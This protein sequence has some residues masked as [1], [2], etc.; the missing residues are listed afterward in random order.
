MAFQEIAGAKAAILFNKAD[1]AC[2]GLTR[3]PGAKAVKV[4]PCI[5]KAMKRGK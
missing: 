2:Y 3:A 4:P 5:A 1:A